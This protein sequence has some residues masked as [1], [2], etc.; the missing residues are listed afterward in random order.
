[1]H[2]GEN[3]ASNSKG[4]YQMKKYLRILALVLVFVMGGIMLASCAKTISGTYEA[5]AEILFKKYTITYEFKGSNF[6]VSQREVTTIG[7]NV[8]T[9]TYEGTYEIIE[10]DDGTMDIVIDVDGGDESF[11]D[12]T[13]VFEQTED[14]IKI[15]NTT[16]YKK[17]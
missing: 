16:Y 2:N 1:M 6:T 10:H 5:E 14:Y 12:G 8:E 4:D 11:K 17:S 3:P 13:Y 7:G 9:K 15:G